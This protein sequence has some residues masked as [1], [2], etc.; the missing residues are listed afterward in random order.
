MLRI[1]DTIS[2]CL[3]AYKVK[4]FIDLKWYELD[5]IFTWIHHSRNLC[6]HGGQGLHHYSN[7]LNCIC[8]FFNCDLSFLSI[9]RFPW[10]SNCTKVDDLKLSSCTWRALWGYIVSLWRTWHFRR[11][12]LIETICAWRWSRLWWCLSC[13]PEFPFFL[14]FLE[15]L[16]QLLLQLLVFSFLLVM[17]SFPRRASFLYWIVGTRFSLGFL[18]SWCWLWRSR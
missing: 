9:N 18:F 8:S 4:N 15:L 10:S 2:L 5:R 17:Y 16:L 1:F 13:R 3:S 7:L 12:I 6:H 14:A 11:P